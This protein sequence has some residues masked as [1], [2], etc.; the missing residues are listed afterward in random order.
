MHTFLI[1]SEENTWEPETNLDKCQDVIEEYNQSLKKKQ[2]RLR[3]SNSNSANGSRNGKK[4]V[5]ESR[6]DEINIRDALDRS[7]STVVQE[8][9]PITNKPV[10][11]TRKNQKPSTKSLGSSTNIPEVSDGL[12]TPSI[13][14]KISP[15]SVSLSSTQE[16]TPTSSSQPSPASSIKSCSTKKS[17]DFSF[18]TWLEELV[19][20]ANMAKFTQLGNLYYFRIIKDSRVEW[21]C[22]DMLES[23]TAENNELYVSPCVLEI[24][25]LDT[26]NN[27]FLDCIFFNTF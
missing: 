12:R 21:V 27:Y 6:R 13:A 11:Q 22:L 14:V 20:P 4:K 23:R 9:L 7:V 5:P 10:L 15:V 16:N 18:D 19:K 24:L 17:E 3:D 26:Y 8:T 1:F 25:L 2:T